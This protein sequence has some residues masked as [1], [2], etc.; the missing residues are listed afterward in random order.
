VI[1][2]KVPG[3]DESFTIETHEAT[4]IS[5]PFRRLRDAS[6]S[7]NLFHAAKVAN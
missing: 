1:V 2:P 6:R 3:F 4:G 7:E 5:L